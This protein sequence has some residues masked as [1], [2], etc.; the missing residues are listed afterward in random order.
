MKRESIIICSNCYE[1]NEQGKEFCYNCG[2]RL[3]Y[4][5]ESFDDE[6]QI[7]N[8][9]KEFDNIFEFDTLTMGINQKKQEL[10]FLNDDE[11][12][13]IIKFASIIECEIIENSKV[14]QGGGVGRAIVGGMIAG[15][16]R[17]NSR[18]NH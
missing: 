8:L 18:S 5:E 11:L 4:N 1:E 13:K 2:K 7:M 10:Y 3:F 12:D 14:L 16:Y 9:K 15:R 6:E 17:S